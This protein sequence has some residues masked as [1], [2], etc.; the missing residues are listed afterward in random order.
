MNLYF[1]KEEDLDQQNLNKMNWDNIIGFLIIILIILVSW[2]KITKQTVAEVIRD[3]KEI[4]GGG[5]DE[6]QERV[7]EVVIYE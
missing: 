5:A 4:I 6:V 1:I 3:I 2:A 7:D